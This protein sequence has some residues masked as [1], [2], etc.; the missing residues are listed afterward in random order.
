MKNTKSN[1]DERQEQVLLKIEHNSF[2]LAFWLLVAGMI[3][4]E[5]VFK[6]D[7]K[8]FGGEC[9]ILFITCIYM[10]IACMRNGIWDRKLQPKTSTNLIVSLIAGGALG[11]VNFF[12]INRTFTDNIGGAIAA[13]VMIGVFTFILCFILLGLSAR[14][15]RK[16]N[17]ELDREPEEEEI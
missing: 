1:L 14:A 15:V 16:K 6:A 13:G 17:E 8:T 12:V 7:I 11:I 3:I 10:A 4:Q 2:W 5:I 9:I